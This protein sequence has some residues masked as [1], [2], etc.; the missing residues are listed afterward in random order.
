V[1]AIE[2]TCAG[3]SVAL[4]GLSELVGSLGANL[5]AAAE[6]YDLTDSTAI[7]KG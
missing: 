5:G 1:A 2:G 3:W 6:A 7:G 4:G